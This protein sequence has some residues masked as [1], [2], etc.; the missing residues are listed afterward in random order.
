MASRM[1]LVR[2]FVRL[3]KKLTVIGIIG[4]TQ[5]VNKANRPPPKPMAKM[6]QSE[7]LLVLCDPSPLRA[8]SLSTTGVHKSV[9]PTPSVEAVVA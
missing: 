5:G 1:P 7:R 9:M 6:S 3:R 2:F 8:W 4:H